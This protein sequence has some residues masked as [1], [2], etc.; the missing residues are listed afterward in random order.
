MTFSTFFTYLVVKKLSIRNRDLMEQS[1]AGPSTQHT[2]KVLL[3][4]LLLTLFFETVGTALLTFRFAQDYTF[5]RA[6]Y[7]GV[8]HAISAFCNAGFSLFSNSLIP[9]R[10]D[11]VVN[12][13]VMFLIIVGGLGFWVLL[14]L[15]NIVKRKKNIHSTSL[16][17]R[18]VIY[19]TTALLIIGFLA[20][21]LFEWGHSFIDMTPFEKILTAAFQSTTTRTA[22]FNT[23]DMASFTN[24]SLFLIILLMIIGASP[25]SC[26]GGIKTSTLAIILAL[27]FSRLRSERQVRLLK[28]GIPEHVISKTI[29][30]LFFAIAIL[31][32]SITILLFTE[33]PPRELVPERMLFIEVMFESASALG[34]VGLSMGLTPL[35]SEIG[36]VCISLLMF[37]GRVGPVTIALAIAGT[38]KANYRF[39]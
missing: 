10:T 18:I 32:I 8:F 15:K 9:Y 22:G 3:A 11:I 7:L 19:T 27:I 38:K 37:I 28:R 35:L 13:T 29:A 17:T 14:D 12:V 39:L 30:I 24:S 25:G 23:I 33:N 5:A 16:H 21:L 31:V 2:G 26:G 6:L 20:I 34:T 4:I 1:I 36:K